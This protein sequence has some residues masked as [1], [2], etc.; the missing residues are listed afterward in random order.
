VI[1]VEPT[2]VLGANTSRSALIL[3]GGL[4]I[5]YGL[6]GDSFADHMSDELVAFMS[7]QVS[8]EQG[9]HRKSILKNLKEVEDALDQARYR[10]VQKGKLDNF[11]TEPGGRTSHGDEGRE[12]RGGGGTRNQDATGRVGTEY[13]RKAREEME[14]R[15]RGKKLDADPMPKV[16]WDEDGA[17]VPAGRAGSYTAPLH[18]VVANATFDFYL[19]MLEWSIEEAKARV[20]TEI[21]EDTLRTICQDEVRRWFEEALVQAVVVLRPMEYDPRWNPNDAKSALSMKRSPPPWYRIAGI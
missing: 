20:A 9:D 21:G 19:D 16:R 8:S 3:K 1:Y 4:P 10:R 7:G 5:D 14:R 2:N 13:L 18:I 11:L 15:L 6:I 12:R 17:D